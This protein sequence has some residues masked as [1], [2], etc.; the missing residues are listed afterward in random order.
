MQ[1]HIAAAE[2]NLLAV[3]LMIE[4]GAAQV[5]FEDRSVVLLITLAF[6]LA[7]LQGS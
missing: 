3:R 6:N 4:E 7:V 2:G 1:L 5:D